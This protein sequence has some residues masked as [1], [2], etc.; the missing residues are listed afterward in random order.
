MVSL[1]ILPSA[2]VSSYKYN[3][4]TL[5][6]ISYSYSCS[7]GVQNE[8]LS[9]QKGIPSIAMTGWKYERSAGSDPLEF[10]AGN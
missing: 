2:Y 3:L 1:N 8:I 6:L 10:G 5:Y 4:V 7:T 9:R